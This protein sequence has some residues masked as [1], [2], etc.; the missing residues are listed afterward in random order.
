MGAN[1]LLLRLLDDD[2]TI[3]ILANTNLVDTDHLGFEIARAV[4]RAA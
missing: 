3:I 1:T 4:L 2:V